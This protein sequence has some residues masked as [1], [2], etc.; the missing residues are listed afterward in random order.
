MKSNMHRTAMA[1][2]EFG[3][4]VGEETCDRFGYTP[5]AQ[6]VWWNPET[7]KKYLHVE[8]SDDFSYFEPYD[9]PVVHGTGYSF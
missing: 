9:G 7:K 5:S 1:V 2:D 8:I 6:Q 3:E 4:E